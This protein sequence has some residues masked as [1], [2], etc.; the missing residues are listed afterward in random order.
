MPRNLDTIMSQINKD[1]KDEI[2]RKGTVR[3]DYDRIP[4]SSPLLQWSTYGGI[5]L[6]KV[7]EICGSEGGGK[8][9]TALDLVGNAQ[10]KFKN[11]WSEKVADL[12]EQYDELVLAGKPKEKLANGVKEKL[13]ELVERGPKVCVYFDL[14][15]TLDE[16][17]AKKLGVATDDLILLRPTTQTG[18]QVLQMAID[19]VNSGDVG[20]L[21]LDSLPMLVPQQIFDDTLEKKSMGGIA[22]L[23]ADFSSR[24]TPALTV[25][26]CALIGINQVRENVGS[27]YGPP[28]TTPGGRSWKHLCSLRIKCQK[29]DLLDSKNLRVPNSTQCPAG[30]MVNTT[31]VKTKIC[32]PNRKGASYTLN[33]EKGIDVVY[34]TLQLCLQYKLVTGTSWY[35]FNDPQTLEPLEDENGKVLKYQGMSRAYEFLLSEPELI[36]DYT[37]YLNEKF[38]VNN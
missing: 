17:W 33:Y 25:N 5:P 1:F 26:N 7:T 2:I 29:G 27:M 30:N 28:E 13:D 19:L 8:T 35:T 9:T 16:M 15:N 20:L 34:D 18:E 31:I 6:G 4:F 37:A 14:E 38:K 12:T 10:K 24:I 22:K 32:S 36:D 11:D 23:L 21:V 3:D